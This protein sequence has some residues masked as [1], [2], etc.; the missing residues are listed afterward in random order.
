[1]GTRLGGPQD[2]TERKRKGGSPCPAKEGSKACHRNCPQ[3]VSRCPC[4]P[5]GEA[6]PLPVSTLPGQLL[7][8]TLKSSFAWLTARQC[9][10]FF[11]G[12]EFAEKPLREELLKLMENEVV[13]GQ[14]LEPRPW[15]I[16]EMEVHADRSRSPTCVQL[17]TPARGPPICIQ[18]PTTAH[19][20]RPVFSS[21]PPLAEQRSTPLTR[22]AQTPRV[23]H[24]ALAPS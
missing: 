8:P 10:F 3:N 22:V 11:H 19:G 4:R 16:W 14:H 2:P 1:M 9:Q 15:R 7:N 24:A 5:Q 18:L 21:Q 12:L 6:S 23:R 17:P 13:G 20:P